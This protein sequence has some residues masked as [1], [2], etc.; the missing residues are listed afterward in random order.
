MKLIQ[1]TTIPADVIELCGQIDMAPEDVAYNC[2]GVSLAIVR[3]GLRPGARVA[4]G[5]AQ[6]VIGQHSWV[7][8]GDP[9][10]ENVPIID[11]TL[12]SYDPDVKGI[13]SG[14]AKENR[15]IPHGAGHYFRGNPPQHHG[16][17]TIYLHPKTPLSDSARK[18]LRMI[19]A[20][21]DAMGWMEVAHLPVEGWPSR[22]IIEAMLDTPGIDVFVPIDIAGMVTDRN[23][24]RLYLDGPEIN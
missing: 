4:R 19:G 1:P 17:D 9:Y 11:A 7:V 22:E 2:H 21:F 20:P 14:T 5:F 18:F 24:G 8:L 16:G 3:A 12:W 6:G 10:D 23:P 15:H 13:W